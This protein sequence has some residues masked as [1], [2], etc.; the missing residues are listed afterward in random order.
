MP[1]PLTYELVMHVYEIFAQD[2]WQPTPGITMSVGLRYDLE[3]MPIEEDPGNPLF[4][5]PSK[6]PVDKDN[7]SPRLGFIWNPDGEGKSAFRAGYG[8]FYDKTLL[9]TID[10]FFTDTK[11]AIVV[12]GAIS[13][14]SVPISARATGSSRPI[15]RS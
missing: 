11:Y 2:K 5:D 3:I 12:R 10:N 1:G 6:Y 14:P 13:R 15:P 7:I 9:G 8:I 4:S